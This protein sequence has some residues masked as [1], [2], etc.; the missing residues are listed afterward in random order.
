M[1]FSCVAGSEAEALRIFKKQHPHWRRPLTVEAPAFPKPE[2][3]G[4]SQ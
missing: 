1:T 2:G 4:K 3:K